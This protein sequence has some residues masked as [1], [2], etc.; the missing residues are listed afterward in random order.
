MR[1][2][3]HSNINGNDYFPCTYCLGYFKKSYLWRHKKNCSANIEN[4]KVRNKCHLS[5]AQTFAACTGLL[6]NY[7]NKSRLKEEVFNIMR[8][9]EISLV[10]KQ[11]PL[12]CLYGE[13]YLNKHKRKQM[14]VVASSRIREMARLK[15]ALMKCVNIE[16][17]I[18][19][20]KPDYYNHIIAAAKLISGYNA[21]NKTFKSPSLAM[22]LGTN[23]KFLCEV[24]RK[25]LITKDQLF[26]TDN[27]ENTLKDILEVKEIINNHWCN[28]ISSIANKALNEQKYTKPKLLPLTEDIKLFNN[29]A[30]KLAAEAYN[31]INNKI[32]IIENYKILCECALAIILIFNRKR[33][34]EVQF[35][36]I[37]TYEKQ[38]DNK[39]VDECL[40]CLSEMEKA[41]SQSLKRIMVLGKGSKPVPILLTKKMKNYIDILLKIRKHT[42]IVPVSNK[43][44]FANPGSSDRW[45]NGSYII[46]KLANKCGA[47]N[48]ELLISTKFR[49]QIATILQLMNLDNNEREQIARFMGHTEKTHL[50]FYR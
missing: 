2:L 22:H 10:A 7:I 23:M 14:N 31:N 13:S 17:L 25:A 4:V 41:L 45:M 33:I 32:N 35:L 27:R 44:V 20:L 43:Y 12:I 47:K 1:S 46:R 49:K 34:G 29:F 50:E 11:D 37:V 38:N 48:P 40:Q 39:N 28:D 30:N 18:Q 6:G 15:M 36:D 5:E 24:A 16:Y 21:E 26:P 19:V 42:D 3:K 8:A 9:D